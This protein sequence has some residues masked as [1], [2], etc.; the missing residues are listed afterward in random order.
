MSSFT[1]DIVFGFRVL[2]KSP[3]FTVAAI[4]LLALG[5]GA[6]TAVFSLLDAV[7]LKPLPYPEANKI[8]MSWNV[9]PAN[10]NLGNYF[11]WAP[12]QFHAMEQETRTYQYLGAF[13]SDTFNLSGSGEPARLD[14]MRVSYGFFPSLGVTPALGRIF[15]RE[16]DQPGRDHEVVLSDALWRGRFAASPEVIGRVI[17]LNGSPFTIIGV[18]KPGFSFPHANEM[19]ESFE[20]PREA[21]LWVPAAIPAVPP[22]N[23]PAELAVVGR[24]QD[25]VSMEQAQAAMDLFASRMDGLMP[26]AKGWFNSRV[27]PLQAQVA[28]DTRRP[29]VLMLSA[30][31]AVLLIVCF[32]L[33]ALMAMRSVQRN[34]EISIRAALGAGGYRIVRQLLAEALLLSSLGAAI[35]LAVCV[36]CIYLVKHLGPSSIPRLQETGFDFRVFAFALAVTLLT[37]LIIGI[38]PALGARRTNLIESLKV[39]GQKAAA[40]SSYPVF[41]GALVVLQVGLSLVLVVICGLLVQTFRHLLNADAGFRP[42]HVITFEVTLPA[43]TYPDNAHIVQFYR[44]ALPRLRAI[45]GAQSAAISEAVPMGGG[46]ESTAMFIVG[47]VPASRKDVP[48]V[49][50]TVVSPE[51]FTTVG[52]PFLRG[53]D[54]LESDNESGQAVAI[55]NQ[56]MARRFWSDQDPMG[57]QIRV[58]SQKAPMTIVGVVADLKHTSVREPAAP[59]VFVPFTQEVWPSLAVMHVVIS[60]R[61]DP[62]AVIGGARA[63]V[64]SLDSRLPLARVA[65]LVSLRDSALSRERFSMLLLAFFAAFSLLL[66]AVG[67]YGVISYSVRHRSREI[68]IRMALGATR[69]SVFKASLGRGFQLTTLGVAL[70][71]LAALAAGRWITNYLYGV[72]SYDP[73]TFAV[74]SIVLALVALLAGVLPSYRAA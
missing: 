67:I 4:L 29:L 16:E 25:G 11:P 53:R 28:G 60:S 17:D 35:G 31:L 52:T 46:P 24:L 26:A 64:Q 30:V 12:L 57:K 42:E 55:I 44:E 18:M 54:F 50:Y 15:S 39:G 59:E 74:V 27:V 36:T 47:R 58:P 20:F 7:L 33:A 3:G 45:P 51:F 19:P 8:V 71:I 66:A 37:T 69:G 21:Q 5:I 23:A 41:R 68:G 40:G 49:N 1:Q 48:M 9:P 63:A 14:G 43:A 22:P 70:G 34:R 65:T 10:L 6:S 61:A 62:D 32:N 13:Q 38:A 72:K 2:K 73:L 56:A